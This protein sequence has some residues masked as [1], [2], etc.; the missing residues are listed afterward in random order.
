MRFF[1]GTM[2]PG[3]ARLRSRKLEA[4]SAD[5]IEGFR[6]H[7]VSHRAKTLE[8]THEQFECW[9]LRVKIEAL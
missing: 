7:A 3:L 9:Y 2:I 8:V 1:D 4:L 6:N 5:S